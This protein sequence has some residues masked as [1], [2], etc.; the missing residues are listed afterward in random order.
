MSYADRIFQDPFDLELR[1]ARRIICAH[2]DAPEQFRMIRTPK[3][4]SGGH[5][6]ARQYTVTVSRGEVPPVMYE[7]SDAM[8]WVAL[9]A[10]DLAT[11]RFS[12]DQTQLTAPISTTTAKRE[13]QSIPV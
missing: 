8:D 1:Q 11:H 10:H 9:F 5:L 7:R 4:Q 13:E 12:K 6:Y 2:G 3:T